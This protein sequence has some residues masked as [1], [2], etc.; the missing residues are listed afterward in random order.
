[1]LIKMTYHFATVGGAERDRAAVGKDKMNME[2]WEPVVI[3]AASLVSSIELPHDPQ[4]H[5]RAFI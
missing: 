2:T 1:M 4:I 3:N 5:C